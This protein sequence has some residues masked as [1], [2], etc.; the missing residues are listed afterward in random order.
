MKSIKPLV[1][2]GTWNLQAIIV[3]HYIFSDSN[4]FKLI[5]WRDSVHPRRDTISAYCSAAENT[6]MDSTRP[7]KFF[8]KQ[9]CISKINNWNC[10]KWVFKSF[11][12]Q[13]LHLA[14]TTLILKSWKL[15]DIILNW[16]AE[17]NLVLNN[18]DNRVFMSRNY[19]S[20]SCPLEI[21][22]S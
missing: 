10:I 14:V 12:F 15:F 6:R 18:K 17:E 5:T 3:H 20:D 9:A 19:R 4:W 8:C 13:I 2:H 22:W 16:G 11:L 7:W 21:W 1:G